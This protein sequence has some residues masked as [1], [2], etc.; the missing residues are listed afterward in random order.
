MCHKPHSPRV[1]REEELPMVNRPTGHS[2]SYTDG[3]DGEHV[4]LVGGSVRKPNPV[5]MEGEGE[6]RVN[7]DETLA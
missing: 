4:E 1:R 3:T 7:R 6:S 5:L 2:L